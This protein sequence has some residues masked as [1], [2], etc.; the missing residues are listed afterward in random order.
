[1][2][3]YSQS[4]TQFITIAKKKNIISKH[5]LVGSSLYMEFKVV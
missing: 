2:N 5:L 3:N 1:M 4:K